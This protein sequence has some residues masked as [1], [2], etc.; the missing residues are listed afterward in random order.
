MIEFLLN[1][2]VNNKDVFTT[3][4]TLIFVFVWMIPLFKW[5]VGQMLKEIHIWF[6]RISESVWKPYLSETDE[7]LELVSKYIQS[8]T[9]Q[10][11]AFLS[12]RLEQNA[13]YEDM[14]WVKR[15]IKS[16]LSTFS[17][18]SYIKQLNKKNT[19]VW[20]LWDYII[21]NYP[22]DIF[23]ED[24]YWYF[25]HKTYNNSQKLNYIQNTVMPEYLNKFLEQLKN[26]LNK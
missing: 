5:F 9:S 4:V 7:I 16:R 21:K 14:E 19:K 23:L 1:L 22:M 15:Q 13:I 11:M 12:H 20:L 10:K 2:A 18:D 6:E 8:A 3:I 17:L 25:F 24:L 26:D